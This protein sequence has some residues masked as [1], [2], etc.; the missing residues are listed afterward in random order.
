MRGRLALLATLAACAGPPA[1]DPARADRA[2]Y[3]AAAARPGDPNP[4]ADIQARALREE[5][6]ALAAGVMSAEGRVDAA[7][8]LCG[9]LTAGPWRDECGFLVVDQGDLE[10]EVAREA[11]DRAGRYADRCRGHMLRKLAAGVVAQ[12]PLGQEPAALAALETLVAAW[13]PGPPTARARHLLAEH[14]AGRSPGEA[15]GWAVCGAA[16]A[17][18]CR[19]AYQHRVQMAGRAQAA[20]TRDFTG[21]PPPWLAAC[22]PPVTLSRAQNLG[23]PI[24]TPESNGVVQEAWAALCGPG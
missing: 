24:W 21:A 8:T 23:L 2:A 16:D 5:C 15:F 18:L 9:T 1:A 17:T 3:A 14:L 19:T 4:C 13:Q 11:C 22:P 20:G 6:V 12:H 7:L 10:P